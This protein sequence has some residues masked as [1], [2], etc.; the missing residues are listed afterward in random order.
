MVEGRLMEAGATEH[1]ELGNEILG[2]L[3]RIDTKLGFAEQPGEAPRLRRA[4]FYAI[5][6]LDGFLDPRSSREKM[7]EATRI[8]KDAV[9]VATAHPELL[10]P[11]IR[12]TRRALAAL[13]V[14][15]IVA[16]GAAFWGALFALALGEYTTAE[17]L[18]AFVLGNFAAGVLMLAGEKEDLL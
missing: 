1:G 5:N 2:W 8:L 4:I 9:K 11:Q 3:K 6:E 15:W 7:S 17:I 10:R 16:L 13:G 14:T 12:L 18:G